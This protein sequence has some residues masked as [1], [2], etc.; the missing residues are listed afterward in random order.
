MDRRAA[1]ES[2][3][4]RLALALSLLLLVALVCA[5]LDQLA[6]GDDEG[7]FVY[8]AQAVLRG[9]PLYSTVWFN[10]LPGFVRWLQGVF[11]LVG[12]SLSAARLSVLLLTV[13]ALLGLWWSS[14]D[15]LS[16]WGSTLMIALLVASTHVVSLSGAVMADV[17][18]AALAAVAV[19]AAVSSMEGERALRRLACSGLCMALSLWFKPTTAASALALLMAALVAPD[20]RQRWRRL[21]VLGGTLGGG[22]LL[23][24]LFED[25]AGLSA[26][27][28]QSWRA[29]QGV[30]S[31]DLGENLHDLWR[32]WV[33]DKYSQWHVA[34]L[35]SAVWGWLALWRRERRQAV[36]VGAWLLAVLGSL[37]LHAPLYRHHLVQLQFPCAYLAAIGVLEAF[38]LCR[39]AQRQAGGVWRALATL[40]LIGLLFESGRGIHSSGWRLQAIEADHLPESVQ[41]IDYLEQRTSPGDLVITDGHILALRAGCDIPP[42]TTNTSRMR[43]KTGQLDDAT[44]IAVAE[45]DAPQAI[46]FWE[47]KLDSLDAFAHWVEAHYDLGVAYSERFR[48]YVLSE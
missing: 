39:G 40:L 43:I 12:V 20:G 26:Q 6:W 17:P 9:H 34:L 16:P 28:L 1:M 14:R 33:D 29:S 7:V 46:V 32:Y 19:A 45:R 27:F 38:A 24:L 23:T 2:R 35:A 13:G 48:I 4:P 5:G 18:S 10:Y 37:I 21:L 8:T 11:A 47:K 44:L 3:W 31:L 30:F 36:V 22:L 25:V 41:A 42:E 15:T